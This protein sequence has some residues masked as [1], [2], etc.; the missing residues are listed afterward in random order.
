MYVMIIDIKEALI[1]VSTDYWQ[2]E[3]PH[4]RMYCSLTFKNPS[5][6]Y[7]P[8]CSHIVAFKTYS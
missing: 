3:A 1:D 7:V 2:S 6:T 5:L 4:W 8:R